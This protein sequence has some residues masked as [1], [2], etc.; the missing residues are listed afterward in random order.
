MYISTIGSVIVI[1]LMLITII[2][3]ENATTK[4]IESWERWEL[5]QRKQSIKS[6]IKEFKLNMEI[7]E[8]IKVYTQKNVKVVNIKENLIILF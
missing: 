6:L 8:I 4:Q 3:T 1:L 2:L 5:I 7:Y